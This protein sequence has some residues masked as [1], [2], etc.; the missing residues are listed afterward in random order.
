ASERRSDAG[1]RLRPCAGRQKQA[2]R[3]KADFRPK[4]D[5]KTTL[6]EEVDA[7]EVDRQREESEAKDREKRISKLADEI[8]ALLVQHGPL[9]VSSIMERVTAR[10]SDVLAALSGLEAQGMAAWKLG[11]KNSH[12]WEAVHHA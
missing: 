4:L 5:S 6:L 2:W 1:S 7:V 8:L 12:V 10:K 9:S 3:P 11:P